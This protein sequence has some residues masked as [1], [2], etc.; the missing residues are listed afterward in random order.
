MKWSEQSTDTA[1]IAAIQEPKLPEFVAETPAAPSKKELR[2]AKKREKAE[3]KAQ[4]KAAKQS[5]HSDD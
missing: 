5:R 4:K 2:E 3:L 1:P